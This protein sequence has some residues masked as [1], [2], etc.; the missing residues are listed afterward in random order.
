MNPEI[1]KLRS[2]RYYQKKRLE[3]LRSRMSRPFCDLCGERVDLGTDGRRPDGPTVHHAVPLAEGGDFWKGWMLAHRR[4]NLKAGS[5][6]KPG[7]AP[8]APAA[9]S[10]RPHDRPSSHPHHWRFTK[11]H[12]WGPASPNGFSCDWQPCPDGWPPFRK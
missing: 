8:V 3:F 7:V 4:C 2:T 12:G 1:E 5:H 6:S 9:L 11:E 10:E